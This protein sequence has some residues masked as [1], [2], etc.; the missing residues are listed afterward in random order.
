MVPS[1]A[2]LK[3]WD[4]KLPIL[5]LIISLL[6]AAVSNANVFT[7]KIS[8]KPRP[9]TNIE[10]MLIDTSRSVDKDVVSRGLVS[11]R[12]KVAKVY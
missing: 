1:N 3:S 9:S 11:L 2:W 6:T 4:Y 5:I 8:E 10:I 7:N 12:E